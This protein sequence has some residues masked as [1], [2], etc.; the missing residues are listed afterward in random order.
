MELQKANTKIIRKS[1]ESVNCKTLF[2]KRTANK[3][4]FIFNETMINVFSNFAP[5]KRVA[6][7]DSEPP[8]MIDYIKNKKETPNI[9]KPTKWS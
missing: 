6:F 4:V 3:Q 5:N 7:D 1:F 8:W 2:N 9:I